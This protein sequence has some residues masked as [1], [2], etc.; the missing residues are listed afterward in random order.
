MIQKYITIS[1]MVGARVKIIGELLNIIAIKEQ[2]SLIYTSMCM[3]TD[4]CLSVL[5]ILYKYQRMISRLG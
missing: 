1:G 3:Y 2:G 5:D 4:T